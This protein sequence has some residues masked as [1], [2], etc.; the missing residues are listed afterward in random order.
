[1]AA[2]ANH[3]PLLAREGQAASADRADQH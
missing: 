3:P 2:P 1:M